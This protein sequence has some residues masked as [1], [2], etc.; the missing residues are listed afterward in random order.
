MLKTYVSI[1]FLA[2]APFA[3][4][5]APALAN[6]QQY[7]SMTPDQAYVKAMALMQRQFA[8]LK[9]E[10]AELRAVQNEAGRKLKDL[11]TQAKA[12]NAAAKSTLIS[13]AT[14]DT[15]KGVDQLTAQAKIRAQTSAAQAKLAAEDYKA[16]GALA[17][18]TDTNRALAAY[19]AALKLAPD[20]TDV[21]NKL[22]WIYGERL[23]R[24][25]DQLRIADIEIANTSPT[26]KANGYNDRGNALWRQGN[27]DEGE[28]A[29]KAALNIAQTSGLKQT[30]ENAFVN[31]SNIAFARRDY[32]A[33]IE[34][35]KRALALNNQNASELNR[36]IILTNLGA[37]Y[38][39][40]NSL[41]EA[42]DYYRQALALNVKMGNTELQADSLNNLG[43]IMWKRQDIAGACVNFRK[44]LAIYEN[45]NA[46]ASEV[47]KT[48]RNNIRD[49]CPKQ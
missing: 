29:Y 19:E 23:A 21:I 41:V 33:S 48:T 46:G 24:Y 45:L 28:K 35:S 15:A 25:G 13:F 49:F 16:A 8:E 40:L 2:L 43:G 9:A 30:E 34:F 42:E 31:L 44:A 17:F 3:Y 37:S 4:A 20:D 47:A 22:M 38:Y 36:S 11:E 39:S 1:G 26:V 32:P 10:N 12:N 6:A 14:G 27:L 7:A 5:A 18:A